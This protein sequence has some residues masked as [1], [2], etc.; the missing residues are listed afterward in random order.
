MLKKNK[1]TSPANKKILLINEQK[2]LLKQFCFCLFSDSIVHL[3]KYAKELFLSQPLFFLFKRKKNII[4]YG[5]A[6]KV[7]SPLSSLKK[8]EALRIKLGIP[9]DAVILLMV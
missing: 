1:Y 9:K 3:S 8:R 7:F 4:L 2:A 5:G 6:D